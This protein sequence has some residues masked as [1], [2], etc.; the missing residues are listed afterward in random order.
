MTAVI[1]TDSNLREIATSV[2]K[3]AFLEEYDQ[4]YLAFIQR[5][6]DILKGEEKFVFLCE[7]DERLNWLAKE[8]FADEIIVLR[9]P[10]SA[11]STLGRGFHAATVITIHDLEK[12]AVRLRPDLAKDAVFDQSESD[13]GDDLTASPAPDEVDRGD[14]DAWDPSEVEVE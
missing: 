12:L 8:E 9:L 7:S 13:F 2:I 10:A 6:A 14:M 1:L 4:S 3:A 11:A 5:L